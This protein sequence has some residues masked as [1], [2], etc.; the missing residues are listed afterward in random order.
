M[1]SSESKKSFPVVVIGAGPVG[2]SLAGDLGW[3]GIPCLR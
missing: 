3:R 2:L 1:T